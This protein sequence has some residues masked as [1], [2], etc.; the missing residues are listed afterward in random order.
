[1]GTPYLALA[2]YGVNFVRNFGKID[3]VLVVP[4]C[5][6]ILKVD[7]TSASIC[8]KAVRTGTRATTAV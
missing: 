7:S 3:R 8:G 6:D 1:M 5:I 2:G 4:R